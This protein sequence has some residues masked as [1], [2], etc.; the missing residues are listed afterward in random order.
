MPELDEAQERRKKAGEYLKMADKL[1]K[2]SDYEGAH[3]LVT[4]AMEADPRNPYAVAY[5]ERIEQSAGRG[6]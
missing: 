2:A 3:S 4:A 1:F 5:K 6:G